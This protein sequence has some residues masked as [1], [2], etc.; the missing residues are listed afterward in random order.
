VV[1]VPS[2]IAVGYAL[3]EEDTEF[4]GKA[5][6][7]KNDAY[8]WA[9]VYFVNYGWVNFNPSPDLPPGNG[10]V[11]VGQLE[12]LPDPGTFVEPDLADL[13]PED[14]EGILGPEFD[15]NQS[16]IGGDDG[17]TPPWTLIWVVVG[18][19]AVGAAGGGG[20]M[21]AWHWQFRGL[22]GTPRL[23]A[24]AQRLGE[25]TGLETTDRETAREWSGRLAETTEMPQE[26]KT[27]SDA[28]QE[29]RYGRPDLVRFDP[30]ETDA[31]Y[32]TLRAALVAKILH[33]KPRER[34]TDEGKETETDE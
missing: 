11:G 3:D 23:W 24:K 31:A 14:I 10:G 7:R 17:F 16:T 34:N 22:E 2:R 18:L 32:M 27:L 30:E 21:F 12:G 33:R 28:Y 29:S 4:N 20:A 9:E 26:S 19:V 8:S 5:T 6:I 1:G 13:L 15:Q 25:W